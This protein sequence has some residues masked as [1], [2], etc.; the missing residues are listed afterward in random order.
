ML[1]QTFFYGNSITPDTMEVKSER[2]ENLS[3][4]LGKITREESQVK[5][6]VYILPS[7]LNPFTVPWSVWSGAWRTAQR[8][9][10]GMGTIGGAQNVDG[11][12]D[13]G[14]ASS[15]VLALCGAGGVRGRRPED[16]A[17]DWIAGGTVKMKGG[18][19]PKTADHHF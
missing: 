18:A 9:G 2:A 19:G 12:C 15:A 4:F 13:N 11:K 6:K 14:E 3:R 16:R 10:S 5:E 1:E 17:D 8:R 7:A